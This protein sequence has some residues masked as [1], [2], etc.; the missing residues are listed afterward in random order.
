M[1]YAGKL[2]VATPNLSQ[3][4]NFR[5]SVVYI[6]DQNPDI[7]VGL[8]LNKPTSRKV[9]D[10][11]ASPQ[12]PYS[13]AYTETLYRGGPV[14]EQS[15]LMMHTDDWQSQNTMHIGNNLCLSSDKFMFEKMATDNLPNAHRFFYGISSWHPAQLEN[16]II[17]HR[18]WLTTE[19]TYSIVFNYEGEDQWTKALDLTSKN[20]FDQYL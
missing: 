17:Q 7:V 5:R 19:A 20:L 16:E 9:S 1:S 15:L 4:S 14:S 10:I 11:F 12:E 13:G 6:Y 3:D 18:A 2:L 8:T